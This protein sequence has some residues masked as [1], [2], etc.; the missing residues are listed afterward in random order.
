MAAGAKL[1]RIKSV[2]WN[3]ITFN[4]VLD[5]QDNY[6][7]N[8]NTTKG[9]GSLT[10]CHA[11][12]DFAGEVTVTYQGWTATRIPSGGTAYDLT[13]VIY[14]QDNNEVTTVYPN[15]MASGPAFQMPNSDFG[16][17]VQKFTLNAG[18]DSSATAQTDNLPTT[19]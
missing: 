18:L 15:P 1:N 2:T 16:T 4:T 19:S 5:I 3:N 6:P 17:Y 8:F 9:G 10:T 12:R 14:D 7:A 11:L 13:C